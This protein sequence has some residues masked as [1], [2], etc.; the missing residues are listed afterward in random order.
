MYQNERFWPC[1]NQMFWWGQNQ[2]SFWFFYHSLSSLVSCE[3]LEFPLQWES[4]TVISKMTWDVLLSHSCAIIFFQ[5]A[6][7]LSLT[8]SQGGELHRLNRALPLIVYVLLSRFYIHHFAVG[9]ST[10][11]GLALRGWGNTGESPRWLAMCTPESSAVLYEADCSVNTK[12]HREDT[13]SAFVSTRLAAW[14]PPDARLKYHKILSALACRSPQAL[15]ASPARCLGI[16]H[17]RVVDTN[18]AFLQSQLLQSAFLP[19]PHSWPPAPSWAEL[20]EAVR[21]L[22]TCFKMVLR[23]RGW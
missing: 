20:P 15:P 14:F 1:H 17:T 8:V 5:C 3:N 12:T 18:L 19:H 23:G 7:P 6:M 16:A 11:F 2:T 21:C 22:R 9:S 4:F 10:C 13:N